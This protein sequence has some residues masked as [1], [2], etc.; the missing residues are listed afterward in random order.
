MADVRGEWRLSP[1]FDSALRW[2]FFDVLVRPILLVVIGLHVRRR[3]LL[4]TSGPAILVAN[5][6]S[7][8]DTM[9]LMLLFSSKTRRIVRPVAAADYFMRN[10]LLAW[11]ATRIVGIL[12]LRRNAIG[13][14]SDGPRRDPLQVVTDAL[15]R[16]EI[17]ILFP[18]GTRGEPEQLSEFRNGAAHLVRKRPEVLVTPVFIHGLGKVLP[19]GEAL[20]VPFFCDA[21]VGAPISWTG[22]RE[23]WMCELR[24]RMSALAAEGKCPGWV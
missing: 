19:K 8:L 10:R 23:S 12:P 7:H 11:F 20:L 6:N 14:T 22:D 24:V 15:D 21:F 5:H 17:V 18:E 13:K 2:L 16:G 4:P 3:H 9:M 1:V